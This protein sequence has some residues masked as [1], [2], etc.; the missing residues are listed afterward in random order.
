MNFVFIISNLNAGGA[1]KAFL[2]IAQS[3]MEM[4]HHVDLILLNHLIVHSPN[5]KIPIHSLSSLDS[6][7]SG[8]F[9]K[10]W[11]SLKLAITW[12]QLNKKRCINLTVSTLPYTDEVVRGAKLPNVYYRIANSLSAEIEQLALKDPKKAHKR[13]KKYLKLYNNQKMIAVGN[14]IKED[15]KQNLQL[16]SPVTTIFN[17]FDK[18]KIQELSNMQD[19]FILN[20]KPFAIHVGRFS[21]QKRHDLLLDAWKIA[22][23]DMKLLL[24]CEPNTILQQMIEERELQEK[25]RIIG[26]QHNPYPYIKHSELLILSSDREGL[27]NVL[28]EALICNTRVVSTNCPFGPEEILTDN[29]SQFLVPTNDCYALAYKI[30]EALTFPKEFF[31]H[32]LKEFDKFESIHQYIKLAK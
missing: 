17:P 3:I 10:K 26:F 11:L 30:Q 15:L 31:S 14:G 9:R 19:D 32:P 22:N 4:G 18:E 25:V 24:L 27:P 12:R 16:S 1:E 23:L 6:N 21:K 7:L 29:L 13:K 5:E 20:L 28:I 8:W 2:N